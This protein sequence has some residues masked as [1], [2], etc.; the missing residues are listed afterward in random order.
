MSDVI[1]TKDKHWTTFIEHHRDSTIFHHPFWSTLLEECY[2]Y[3]SFVI[4]LRNN[5]G[6]IIAGLPVMEIDSWLT[7][8]RWVSLPFSDHCGPLL[9][10]PDD[11]EKFTRKLITKSN[12]NE[13]LKFEIRHE[14]P[15]LESDINDKT[16]Y[17]HSLELKKDP[18]ELFKRFRKKG[19]QYCIKKA[20]R[21]GI[22]ISKDKDLE[23]LITFFDLH[24][25]T[26]KKLGVPTQPKKYFIKL[27]EY[28]IKQE[29]GFTAIAYYE[30]EPVAGGVFLHYNKK[31]TYKYG[32]TAPGSMHLYANHA[33]L[34]DVIQ[35]GCRNGFEL[36]DWGRTDKDNEGLRQFK[37]GWGS[38]EKELKYSQVGKNSN[39]YS[40]GWKQNIIKNIVGHSPSCVGRVLGELLY[41][42][43]G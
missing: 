39:D 26:R 36:F 6:E 41:K 9:Q 38:D 11:I 17:I 2:G 18:D 27:W 5:E 7:G 29:L 24:L 40:K 4:V 1:D 35:W 43:I 32:A 28:I 23:S 34:W 14:I 10:N 33:L 16:F 42:H 12:E 30:G 21:S 22:V 13:N 8:K 3:K 19:V 31:L 25:M 20:S 15:F 37:L